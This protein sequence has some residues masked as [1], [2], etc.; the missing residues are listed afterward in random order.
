MNG[1]HALSLALAAAFGLAGCTTLAPGAQYVV[2]GESF[3]SGSEAVQEASL[4][5]AR[6]R[7]A[8]CRAVSVGGY[9]A[10]AGVETGGGLVIGVPVLVDCPAGVRLLPSGEPAP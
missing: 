2:H 9:G 7:T 8:G 6:A 4:A 5:I 10:G 1:Y 3:A